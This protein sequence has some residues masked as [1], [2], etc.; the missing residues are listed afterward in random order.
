MPDDDPGR[1]AHLITAALICDDRTLLARARGL[2]RTTRDR[3]LAAI[4]AAHL[5]RDDDLLDAL[6]R[7]HL[8]DHPDSALAAW[9]GARPGTARSPQPEQE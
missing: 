8:V 4:A 1:I 9:V 3:Q 6:V 2:A 7:D 5:D